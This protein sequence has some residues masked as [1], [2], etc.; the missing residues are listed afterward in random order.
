M[1]QNLLNIKEGQKRRMLRL[2]GS[3]AKGDKSWIWSTDAV[4][5]TSTSVT[6]EDLDHLINPLPRLP[7]TT[8]DLSENQML[9][10]QA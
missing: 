9:Q 8:L 2:L 3:K 1:K 4:R 7:R 5:G 6:T 10:A